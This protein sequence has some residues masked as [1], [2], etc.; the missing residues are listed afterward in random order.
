MSQPEPL[1]RILRAA[2]AEH[3]VPSLSAAVYRGDEVVWS[4]AVGAALADGTEATPNTQYRVGS[5]S[6]TFT[7]AAIMLLRDEGKLELGVLAPL[8]LQLFLEPGDLCAHLAQFAC[9]LLEI[10]RPGGVDLGGAPE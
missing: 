7:A 10:G 1:S 4:E 9:E 6:K 3:R 8:L 5:I 2:Q